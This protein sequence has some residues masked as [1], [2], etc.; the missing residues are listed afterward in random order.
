M[1]VRAAAPS[2]TFCNGVSRVSVSIT[3]SYNSRDQRNGPFG[4]GWS[5]NYGMQ[6]IKTT[7]GVTETVI[8]RTP[9]GQRR[10]YEKVGGVYVPPTGA[11]ERL[12]QIGG[13]LILSVGEGYRWRFDA[14]TSRLLAIEHEAGN[15]LLLA[16]DAVTGAIDSL[17]DE[18]SGERDA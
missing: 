15:R 14:A 4:K 1:I 7:D 13:E 11:F 17:T 12:E 3:R 10:R 16:Y 8:V 6:A 5:F 9:Q 18:D 2:A